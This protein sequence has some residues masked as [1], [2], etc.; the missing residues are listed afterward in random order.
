V[1]VAQLVELLVVVQ[2]AAGSSPVVHPLRN[3]AAARFLPF[4]TDVAFS[5]GG[6]S[7][8]NFS[9]WPFPR[10]QHRPLGQARS[11]WRTPFPACLFS[12]YRVR[13]RSPGLALRVVPSTRQQQPDARIP[14]SA[15]PSS[16]PSVPGEAFS[17]AQGRPERGRAVARKRREE[18]K[19]LKKGACGGWA[20]IEEEHSTRF[21]PPIQMSAQRRQLLRVAGTWSSPLLEPS[22]SRGTLHYE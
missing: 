13:R 20:Q 8:D 6:Q 14:C 1:D 3:R 17:P 19:A 10:R 5:I 7:G 11:W 9:S 15:C 12:E 22:R 2:V 18:R 4:E 21:P 16:R